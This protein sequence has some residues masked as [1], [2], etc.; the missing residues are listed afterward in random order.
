MSVV[1][2]AIALLQIRAIVRICIIL[3]AFTM[4]RDGKG[5]STIYG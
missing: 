2:N 4:A 3:H 5:N 1:I